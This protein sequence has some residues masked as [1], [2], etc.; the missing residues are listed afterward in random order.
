MAVKAPHL[1]PIAQKQKGRVL[2]RSH[3]LPITQIQIGLGFVLTEAANRSQPNQA[4]T[5]ERHGARL[6][7]AGHC[8][9]L[10][11]EV[12]Y[13]VVTTAYARTARPSVRN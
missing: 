6:R 2:R 10:Y 12:D 1:Q 9:Q 5:E 3:F 8:S 13:P 11:V 7:G 4:E